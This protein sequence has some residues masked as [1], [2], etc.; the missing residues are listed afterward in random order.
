V[1]ECLPSKRK[2]LSAP[3][4]VRQRKPRAAFPELGSFCGPLKPVDGKAGAATHMD[5]RDTE[6]TLWT[7]YSFL[8]KHVLRPVSA[9]SLPLWRD[10]REHHLQ[11]RKVSDSWFPFMAAWPCWV[12]LWRDSTSWKKH[13]GGVEDEVAHLLA[14]RKS[15]EGGERLGPNIAAGT[16]PQWPNLLPLG[17]TPQSSHCLPTALPA[18]S[19]AFDHG[20]WGTF[21]TQL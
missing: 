14:A 15:T 3:S 19:Q 12:G 7:I 16:H 21:K 13:H 2:A 4:I 5:L 1:R 6:D 18:S 8:S 9:R 11:R 17:P 20:L 10:T